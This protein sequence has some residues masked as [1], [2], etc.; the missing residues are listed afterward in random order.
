MRSFEDNT[1]SFIVRI[2]LEPREIQNE[3]PEWRGMIE[4]LPSGDRRYLRD[5]DEI[6]SF[7]EICVKKVKMTSSKLQ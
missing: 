4:H 2:W 1:H 6:S 5:L 3:P 7:I